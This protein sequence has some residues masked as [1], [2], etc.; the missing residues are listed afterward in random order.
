MTATILSGVFAA[1]ALVFALLATASSRKCAE[2]LSEMREAIASMR[3]TRSKVEAHD[4]E[5]EAISD[6]LATLRGKFYAERR[7]SQPGTTN[8]DSPEEATGA[9]TLP[10]DEASRVAWKAN[11]RA[12]YGLTPMPRK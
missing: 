3:S 6:A 4:S 2:R 10:G 9:G 1:A 11:M 5:I 7:K 8:S 12:K